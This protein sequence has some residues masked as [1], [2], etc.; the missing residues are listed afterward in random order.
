MKLSKLM[1]QVL[2]EAPETTKRQTVL[3]MAEMGLVTITDFW[4]IRGGMPGA[5]ATGCKP[6]AW[7]TYFAV[8]HEAIAAAMEKKHG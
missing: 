3:K 6:G 1:L 2:D 7:V 5:S 8:N 4:I